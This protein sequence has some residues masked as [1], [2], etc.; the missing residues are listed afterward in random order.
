[1]PAI[2]APPP[3]GGWNTIAPLMGM[4]PQF[5]VTLDNW[6]PM[7][8]SLAMRP[9]WRAWATGM[10]G[11]IG[12]LMAY[13][14]GANHQVFAASGTGLYDVTG[15]G[16]VAAPV[17]TGF[18]SIGAQGLQ[19]SAGGGNFLL[20][21][22][23]TSAEQQ[24]D[25]AAWAPWTGTGTP[26]LTWANQFKTRI[27]C[28]RSDVLSFWY[29]PPVSIGGAFIEFPLQGVCTR[30]GGVA[31]GIAWTLDG[32][33]G[34]DDYWAMITTEGELVV[35]KGTD[36]SST[37]AW[38]LVGK[39]DIPRPIGGR[40][41]R[42]FGAD[43]LVLTEGGI[44]P[45]SVVATSGVDAAIL[46][47]KA[48]TR[49]IEP[50]FLE[51]VRERRDNDGW[52]LVNMPARG[53]WVLNVPWG[54]R[55]AQQIAFHAGTGACGRWLGIPASCWLSSRIGDFCGDAEQGR[56]LRFG[57]DTTDGGNSISAEAVSAFS[58]FGAAAQL[59]AFRL[60]MPVMADADLGA[61]RI[62]MALD[63]RAPE[64]QAISRGPAAPPLAPNESEAGMKWDVDN[65]DEARWAGA[66]RAIRVWRAVN[67]IG[68]SGA[69]RLRVQ[70]SEASPSWFGTGVVFEVGG[71]LR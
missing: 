68:Q 46:P 21:Y 27:M 57:D 10:P 26:R 12:G 37:T 44:Y 34:P 35:F 56:V 58:S 31:G 33:N 5:A 18:T 17:T 16:A 2:S 13:N 59:K 61:V 43:V 7:E 70:A 19:V 23:G 39:W 53:M 49:Q 15:P 52:D 29:G 22:N 69:I 25:G 64:A 48:Y 42:P 4:P 20:V 11:R 3:T 45:L 63:W 9:G 1:V 65:W 24:F 50:T 36:P 54:P 55:D 14:S 62:E 41:L 66:G 47:T 38:G 60:A 71:P 40:F 8:G 51:L 30:G 32:G 6:V 67:G 28:G